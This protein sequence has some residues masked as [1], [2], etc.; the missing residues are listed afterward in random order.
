MQDRKGSDP[1]Y[2]YLGPGTW[3]PCPIPTL[4]ILT[5]HY[6]RAGRDIQL[7][8]TEALRLRDPRCLRAPSD[9]DRGL[10]PL[11]EPTGPLEP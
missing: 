6:P 10:S 5:K 2:W 3:H 4:Q 7:S 1:G 11:E 9:E 8:Y